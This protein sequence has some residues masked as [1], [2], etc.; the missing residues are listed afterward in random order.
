VIT[1]D[2]VSKS[3]GALEILRDVSL[4]VAADEIVGVVGSSGSGKTTILK[5]ITGILAADSGMVTVAEGP[6]GYA[7][8]EPRLLPWRTA[9]DNVAAP[10]RAQ[11]MS[12]E[13]ARA[14]AARWLER[15]EL[16]G[17]ERYRPA[18]LSGGM[19]QR[20]SL[21]RAFAVEPRILLMDEPFSNVDV[22]LKGSLMTTL[23]SMIKERDTTM[24][25][26]THEL[27]EALRL[28]DRIV[29]LTPEHTLRELD[30]RDRE[31]LA[32]EWLVRGT[33]ERG[34]GGASRP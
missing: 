3:F 33:G 8:Q 26:V 12:K 24:V 31:A 5:L 6:V 9:L 32:R 13:A 2:K 28:A 18:E 17:F 20:V 4:H 30:L 34:T 29:E 11:G 21:A 27:P 16:A 1:L 14:A 15:V 22:D 25:Y 23:E 10:L 19:A 7:F